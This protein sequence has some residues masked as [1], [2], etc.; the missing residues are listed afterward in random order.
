MFLNIHDFFGLF[1]GFSNMLSTDSLRQFWDI[2][3]KIRLNLPNLLSYVSLHGEARGWWNPR[4]NT[5][6]T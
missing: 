4:K 5:D 3:E 6:F 1:V 2:N